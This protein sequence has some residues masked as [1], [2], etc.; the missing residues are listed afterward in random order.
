MVAE[1]AP[2]VDFS[3]RVRNRAG[4]SSTDRYT[5]SWPADEI[6]TVEVWNIPE[7]AGFGLPQ[8]GHRASASG[9]F[10]RQ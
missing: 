4:T 10:F 8:C 1:F 5:R 3:S 6:N 7:F 2:F 9:I